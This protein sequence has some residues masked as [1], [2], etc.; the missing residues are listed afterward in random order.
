[1][2]LG[3]GLMTYV[4]IK[5]LSLWWGVTESD[6]KHRMSYQNAL[7]RD[8]DITNMHYNMTSTY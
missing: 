3:L 2:D 6:L 7:Y 5:P 8:S 1:M 4:D